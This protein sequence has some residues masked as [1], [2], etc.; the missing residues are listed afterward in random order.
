MALGDQQFLLQPGVINAAGALTPG[1]DPAKDVSEGDLRIE[2]LLGNN[3]QVRRVINV[4]PDN[5]QQG[6][7]TYVSLTIVKKAG[8]VPASIEFEVLLTDDLTATIGQNTHRH[9]FRIVALSPAG[10]TPV[11]LVTDI[12][13]RMFAI[14]GVEGK[15]Q[16]VITHLGGDV[17]TDYDYIVELTGKKLGS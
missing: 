4:K 3:A 2:G 1:V 10:S 9:I 5:I 17:D 14:K 12:I 16:V 13:S 15:M 6:E 8:T 7:L 11:R